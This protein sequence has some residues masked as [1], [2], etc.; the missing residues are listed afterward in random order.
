MEFIRILVLFFIPLESKSKLPMLTTKQ[1][2]D[3]LRFISRDGKYTYYQRRSGSLVLSTNYSNK[4]V[5]K[6]SKGTV[7]NIISSP[8]RKKLL[9]AVKKDFHS[10]YR[11]RSDGNIM[12]LNFGGDT[13]KKAG[14]GV[15]PRLHLKDSWL[16]F[17]D[18]RN[19]TIFFKKIDNLLLGFEIKLGNRINPYFIPDVVMF[20]KK[21]IL[22]TDLNKE[23]VFG[24]VLYDR[25]KNKTKVLYKASSIHHQVNLC[26]HKDLFVG[27]FPMDL[28]HGKSFILK[29]SPDNLVFSKKIYESK[30]R[31]MGNMICDRDDNFI[32]FVQN[33]GMEKGKDIFEVVRL[34]LKNRQIETLSDV[35][36]ASQIIQ[37]D[38]LLL[39]PWRG[40][41]YV[42]K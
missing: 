11:F 39:L 14:V 16:S 42:L 33:Q 4:E 30:K 17:F 24:I 19:Q 20:D 21:R 10:R 31:D 18:S 35:K 41:F 36:Y 32:Y 22:Y 25:L 27:V 7:Y 8:H 28:S 23:G 13:Y 40:D 37:M 34:S 2:I 9:V 15:Y 26:F 1:S 38:G 12:I 3:N 5:I 29:L 6:G